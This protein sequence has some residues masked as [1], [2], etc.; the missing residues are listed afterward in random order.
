MRSLRCALT[1]QAGEA[2]GH[3][4]ATR[5]IE[6]RTSLSEAQAGVGG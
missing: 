5:R 2:V 6:E 1:G 4:L 3:A